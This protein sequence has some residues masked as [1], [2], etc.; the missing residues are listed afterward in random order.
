MVTAVLRKKY[1]P[2]NACKKLR[3]I[4]E[5]VNSYLKH[6]GVY[7]GAERQASVER[8]TVQADWPQKR[9]ERL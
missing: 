1:K 6:S 7:L 9:C 2:H 4:F 3:K 8:E 5:R